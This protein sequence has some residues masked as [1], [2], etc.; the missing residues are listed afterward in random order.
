M[1]FYNILF[2]LYFLTPFMLIYYLAPSRFK[3][4]VLLAAGLIYGF[5]LGPVYFLVPLGSVLINYILGRFLGKHRSIPLLILGTAVNAAVPIIFRLSVN[6]EILQKVPYLWLLWAG[7]C[8]CGLRALTYLIDL[9]K[10]TTAIQPNL[11]RFA[12]FML[13]FPTFTAGPLV[14][15]NDFRIQLRKRHH[16]GTAFL[17]GT[18]YFAC[19]ILKKVIL[20]DRLGALWKL[21]STSDYNVLTTA[22]ALLGLAALILYAVISVSS[23]WDCAVGLCR[24]TGFDVSRSFHPI[25]FIKKTGAAS[26]AYI[27]P[28]AAAAVSVLSFADRQKTGVFLKALTKGTGFS[29]ISFLYHFFSNMGLLLVSVVI[30]LHIP[31]FAARLV[32]GI[33]GKLKKGERKKDSF[34][35]RM[36]AVVIMAAMLCVSAVNV[37]FRDQPARVP[38]DIPLY[39]NVL[40]DEAEICDWTFIFDEQLEMLNTD[41]GYLM[42]TSGKNGVYYAEDGSLIKR[43]PD[44]NE[45]NVDA[46]IE[47]I[48]AVSD[49]ERYTTHIALIPPAYEINA[50]K[51]PPY[52]HD[53]RVKKTISRVYTVLDGSAIRLFDAGS[54][55]SENSSK[56]LYYNTSTELTAEG[57][58]IIYE[59]V[60]KQLGCRLFGYD[61]FGF[62]RGNYAYMGDLWREAGTHFTKTDLY[63]KPAQADERLDGFAA[64]LSSE[65][66]SG[67]ALVLI[68]D[69]TAPD[70]ERLLSKSFDTVYVFRAGADKE[71]LKTTVNEYI[72]D[73]FVTDMLVVCSTDYIAG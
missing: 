45:R 20:A 6:A 11:L 28:I 58:Y 17:A 10:G 31:W 56:E 12:N 67:R 8:M 7:S 57:T 26:A 36:T 63:T 13:Y 54:L 9:Y 39:V 19:G 50:D 42:K 40:E 18:A 35:R 16:T 33:I 46:A 51:L 1:T 14:S 25:K 23:Y 64:V 66:Q 30:A 4:T 59:A 48:D 37:I 73:K 65:A 62:T 32:R 47:T 43:P 41:A 27:F 38:S 22:N 55:L 15:Y 61:A 24:I 44:Y 21:I 3:N 70:I 34:A 52:A 68:T 69:G 53:G 29:E 49:K 71:R 2:L 60:A 5:L 72:G